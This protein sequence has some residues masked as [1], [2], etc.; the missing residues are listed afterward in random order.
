MAC[1]SEDEV[2]SEY[3][4][5]TEFNKTAFADGEVCTEKKDELEGAVDLATIQE[6]EKENGW[7]VEEP[8]AA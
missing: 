5:W 3:E 4:A 1:T 7:D 6:R 8:A 2:P